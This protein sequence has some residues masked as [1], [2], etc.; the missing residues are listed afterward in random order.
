MKDQDDAMEL[1]ESYFCGV[2]RFH[3]Y[4]TF[5]ALRCVLCQGVCKEVEAETAKRTARIA[6]MISSKC[7]PDRI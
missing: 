6:E 7:G 2:S 3:A 5:D 1:L 4:Y